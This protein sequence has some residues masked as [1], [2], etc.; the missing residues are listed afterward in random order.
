[1]VTRLHE[2]AAKRLLWAIPVLLLVSI[3]V[4]WM[5]RLVPGD[6]AIVMLGS[7]ATR[8]QIMAV[9]DQMGLDEP[10]IVQYIQYMTNVLQGDLGVSPI[11]QRRVSAAILARLPAT[12]FVTLSGFIVSL[13]IAIPAGTISALR[14]GTI[15]DDL[16]LTFGLLGVS[17]PNFWLGIVLLLIFGVYLGWFPVTG[18]VSPLED[19]IAGI[20]YMILPGITLGTAMAA[21][22]TRMLRSELLEEIHQDYLNAIRMK[23]VSELTVLGHAMKNAFI[24]VIT[25]IGLQFGYLLGGSVIIE[26]VF[27][28]PGMGRLLVN[29]IRDRDYVMIQGIVLVYTTFF[30]LVNLVVDLTY[31]YLNPRLRDE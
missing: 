11:D 8:E 31:F 18:Y 25:V 28:I 12:I 22:V 24:P 7:D 19:P 30:V 9:R 13:L 1:M 26:E 21:I 16:G 15:W 5:V 27:T 10:F 17:I 6:P 20:K 2:Y 14:R 23:G 29:R 4:S 3:I